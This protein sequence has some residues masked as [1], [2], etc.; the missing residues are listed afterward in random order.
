MFLDE[1]QAFKKK[2]LKSKA[3]YLR[4]PFLLQFISTKTLWFYN[5]SMKEIFL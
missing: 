1:Q 3:R 4:T 2:L 5:N